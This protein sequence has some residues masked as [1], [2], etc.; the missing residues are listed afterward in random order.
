[1][2]LLEDR[3]AEIELLKAR[4]ADVEDRIT[5]GHLKSASLSE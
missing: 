1:V 3:L 5:H 2:K 4:L